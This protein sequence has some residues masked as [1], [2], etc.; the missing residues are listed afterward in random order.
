MKT[1]WL[2][3]NEKQI[4]EIGKKYFG[5][6]CRK[7]QRISTDYQAQVYKYALAYRII[8][9][10]YIDA[11]ALQNLKEKANGFD[12]TLEG[13]IFWDKIGSKDYLY[14]EKYLTKKENDPEFCQEFERYFYE[15]AA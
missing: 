11:V 6:E 4:Q 12:T 9:G 5:K 15:F 8:S 13:K 2:Y 1:E 10:W 3:K 14:F 7:I